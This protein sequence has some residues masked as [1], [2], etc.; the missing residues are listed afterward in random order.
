MR[1]RAYLAFRS[2]LRPPS[3]PKNVH[4][5]LKNCTSQQL[6]GSI[7][8][9]VVAA[10]RILAAAA[11]PEPPSGPQTSMDVRQKVPNLWTNDAPNLS[12]NF[13]NHPESGHKMWV[14]VK[15]RIFQN[16]HGASTGST[17]FK[18]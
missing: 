5:R 14:P 8:S 15:T 10:G 3:T 13:E 7:L 4:R 6:L 9:Y 17:F 18:C 16:K 2:P 1:F 11:P 12:E